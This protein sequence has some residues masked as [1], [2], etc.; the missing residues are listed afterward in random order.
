V[1]AL[2]TGASG[3]VGRHLA[4]HLEAEGDTVIGLDRNGAEP[5]D[6]TDADA[7]RRR[8]VDA[9]PEAVYHLAALTH[10]GES[11]DQRDTVAAVNVDGTRNVVDACA[12]TSVRAVVVVGSAEQYGAVTGDE[13]PIRESTPQRPLSPYAESKVAAEEVAQRAWSERRVPVL[14]V[15]AFNHTGPGQS[16]RFLVPAL[17]AR[18]VAAEAGALDELVVGNLDPVRDVSDVRDVVRAYRLLV[19]HG[20][21]GEAY[22]VCSGRGVSVRAIAFGLLSMAKRELR[23]A[24]DPSL[25]RPVDAPVL[26]G[27]GAKIRYATGWAPEIDLTRTLW[28]VLHE[29]RAQA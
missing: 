29:A 17:A 27:D 24:V 1:R 10:V 11:W 15:R 20:S 21:P 23:L 28:E 26:I 13:L 22:N 4:A 8:V 9:Q 19:R 7:V 3:F 25:V 12:G 2:V 16:P 6:I 14:L 18:I 5:T